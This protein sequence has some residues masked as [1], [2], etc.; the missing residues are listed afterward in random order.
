MANTMSGELATCACGAKGWIMDR[1][2]HLDV[3]KHWF[4][5]HHESGEVHR[6]VR[7]WTDKGFRFEVADE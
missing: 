1:A 6:V 2:H 3:R 4:V 5:I 7:V